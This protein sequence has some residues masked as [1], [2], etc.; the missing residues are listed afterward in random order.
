MLLRS[1]NCTMMFGNTASP[2]MN[3]CG[4]A[5]QTWPMMAAMLQHNVHLMLMITRR[6]EEKEERAGLIRVKSFGI[7]VAHRREV[8][9]V[10]KMTC[11]SLILFHWNGLGRAA[12]LV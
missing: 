6:A 10:H 7:T 5:E 9:M 3:G 1:V 2:L 12:H 8:F 11:G 4:S